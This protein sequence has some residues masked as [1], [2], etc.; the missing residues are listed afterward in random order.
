MK[1]SVNSRIESTKSQTEILELKN[2]MTKTK[3]QRMGSQ[4]AGHQAEPGSSKTDAQRAC[5]LRGREGSDGEKDG[6]QG[7]AG[8]HHEPDARSLEPQ[9]RR[10]KNG[11]Q[12]TIFK[13]M[14]A[15]RFPDLTT[16]MN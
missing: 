1:E 15:E 8:R 9:G 10:R 2:A 7:P 11:V 14:M 13:D 3:S 16:D 6:P 12:K 4:W 5:N